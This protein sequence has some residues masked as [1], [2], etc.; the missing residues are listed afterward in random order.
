[1]PFHENELSA[2]VLHT[3]MTLHTQYGPGLFESVYEELL[4]YELTKHG[5]FIERQK[6]IPLVHEE[7]KLDIGFRADLI[8]ERKVLIEIKSVQTLAD[9]HF[10]QVLTY[11]K[12]ADLKLGLLINFNESLL[13]NG[14]HRVANKL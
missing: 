12:L 2:Q 1:M 4:C 11:L 3:A 14:F 7:V 5:L 9:V 10:K 8:V 13:K 6:D